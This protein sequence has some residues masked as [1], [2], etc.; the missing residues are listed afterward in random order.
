ME[1]ASRHSEVLAM[2]LRMD[3][4]RATDAMKAWVFGALSRQNEDGRVYTGSARLGMLATFK[5]L[6]LPR[7][8]QVL[9]PAYSCDVVLA[10]IV[11]LGLEPVYYGVT[12]DLQIDFGSMP[13]ASDAKA[14][15]TLNYFGAGLDFREMERFARDRGLV[16]LSDNS[17]GFASTQA[18]RGLDEYGDF[19]VTSFYKV[20]PT[21]NGAELRI[22]LP[23]HR[24]LE[25]RI[26]EI[27]AEAP[28]ESLWL[29]YRYQAPKPGRLPDF[30]DIRAFA[31]NDLRNIAIHPLSLKMRA[32][33]DQTAIRERRIA[34]YRA[35]DAFFVARAY[36]GVWRNE[37]TASILHLRDGNSPLVYPISVDDRAQWKAILAEARRS[38][39]DIHTWPSLPEAVIAQNLFG[40]VERWQRLLCLPIHQNIDPAGYVASLRSI[41]DKTCKER[42]S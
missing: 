16:W 6:E 4:L 36:P 13:V 19:S 26:R 14:I 11:A 21:G 41:F 28:Q 24:S 39:V 3:L 2:I 34:L 7:G 25:R 37:Q 20:I 40:S 30:S 29:F 35:L 1:D 5:A 32:T 38:D 15:I 9:L 42:E 12:H 31:D 10:P 33:A 8:T 17:H 18:G 23:E 22:N 27:V